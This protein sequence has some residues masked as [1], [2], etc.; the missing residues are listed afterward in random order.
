MIIDDLMDDLI[1]HQEFL[2]CHTTRKVPVFGDEQAPRTLI[3]YFLTI[4]TFV[5]LCIETPIFY[6]KL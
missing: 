2:L 4:T 6:L 3:I 5:L 1:V